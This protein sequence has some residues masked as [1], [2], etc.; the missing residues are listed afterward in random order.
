MEFDPAIAARQAFAKVLESGEL[1]EAMSAAVEA[2]ERFASSVGDEAAAAYRD[3]IAMGD[4]HPEAT[5]FREFLVYVTWSHLMEETLPEH[6]KRGLSL[7]QDL[8]R[9]D[10]GED[11]ERIKRLRAMERSLR[12]GLG[13]KTE[14][15]LD[16]DA[17]LPKGGD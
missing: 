1:G 5:T 8:L 16:Y 17:D 9:R 12:T 3:L 10:L 14:A 6:F 4:Q 2:E 13:D 7:C 15:L 11:G